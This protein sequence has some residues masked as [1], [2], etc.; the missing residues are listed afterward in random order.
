MPSTPWKEEALK[1]WAHLA[2]SGISVRKLAA[3]TGL[4]RSK[5]H[6]L[7]RY[8]RDEDDA[9]QWID[10]SQQADQVAEDREV[11]ASEATHLLHQFDYY[12]N[13][14]T[15]VYVTY[16]KCASKPLVLPGH[17]HRSMKADY[18]NWDGQPAT[19]NQICR[20][21]ELPR[22]WFMEY[23]AIHGWTH[24]SEPFSNEELL[25]RDTEDLVHDALQHKRQQLYQQYEIKRWK[26]IQQDAD[27]WNRFEQEVLRQITDSIT[28]HA[29]DYEV[30]YVD[31]G[32]TDDE[33]VFVMGLSDFHWGSYAWG[34]ETN[35]EYNREIAERRMFE[36]TGRIMNRLPSN[37][38]EIILPVGSDFFDI[39]GDRN[40]TTKGTPQDIDGTPTEILITGCQLMVRYIDY[41]SQYAPVKVVMMAGNH[42]RHNG[43]AL[44]LYLSAWYRAVEEVDVVLEYTPRI[45]LE[46]GNNLIAFSHGDGSNSKPK[47]LAAIISV[48][49]RQMWGRTENHIAF[50]GHLHHEKVHE[51]RGLTHYQL[52]SLCG[53]DRWH[54]RNGWTTSQP[55]LQGFM[56]DSQEGVV[57]TYTARVK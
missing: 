34:G 52:P 6:W 33:Y 30:P 21:F 26:T 39:D 10:Q 28:E 20:R 9:Q 42:D 4:S 19:I 22:P 49:A 5:A 11:K 54:T 41:L 48:E 15:D 44:L 2:A 17:L 38:S 50:G 55:A 24:D 13:D 29:P 45:Y 12:Y 1:Q 43:L 18:S 7:Y 32:E 46:M 36:A 8:V 27:K 14:Q 3:E 31:L 25:A 23:K 56:I 16:L 57:G 40:T 35:G 37:P 47:D 53:S 51:I